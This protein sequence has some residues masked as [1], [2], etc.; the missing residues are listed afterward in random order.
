MVNQAISLLN[1]EHLKYKKV[2]MLSDGERQKAFIAKAMA[3]ET[4]A[5]AVR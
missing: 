5:N 4:T 3:Q 1:I 2:Q